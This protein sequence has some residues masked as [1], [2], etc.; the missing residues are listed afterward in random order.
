MA[1]LLKIAAIAASGFFRAGRFFPKDGVVVPVGDL[2]EEDIARIRA[3]PNLHVQDVEADEINLISDDELTELL[4]VAI[5]ALAEDGFDKAGK[6]K[7]EPLRAA[8][9]DAKDRI[10][11]ELRDAVWAELKPAT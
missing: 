11:A 8:I 6:P 1:S 2:T 7:L 9:P 5:G 3:E 4:K 10:T